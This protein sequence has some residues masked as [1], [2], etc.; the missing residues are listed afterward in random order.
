MRILISGATGFV[1]RRLCEVLGEAGNEL[2]A[3]SRHPEAAKRAV[4]QLT[5]A[6]LWSA[7]D[8]PP[9]GESL[10]G[11]DAIVHLAGESV[12][13]RWTARK[14]R[15]IRDSRVLGTRRLVDALAATQ[16]PP[17]VLVAASAIGYYGDR[18]DEI[19][20]EDS[21]PGTDFL[22]QVCQGWE[23]EAARAGELG[24]RVVS[25]RIGVVLG[26]GGGALQAMLPPFR[27]GVGG[28]LGSGRQWWSWVQRDDLVGMIRFALDHQELTGPYNAT[29]PEPMRQKDFGK[30]LGRVLHRPAFMPTP[31]TALKILLGGFS[32][33]LLSSK[34]VL[35]SRMQQTGYEFRFP[36]LEPALSEALS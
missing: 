5:N 27:M 18:G 32:S 7:T 23:A 30:V 17:R 28:P 36:R 22:A 34:R 4:P 8:S 9:P 35:P 19:L 11:V 12:V 2:T 33:E 20:K 31:A 14:T 15:A 24:V 29:S 10:A 25:L 16:S 21:P 6:F 26:P 13:G 1:G 3:L